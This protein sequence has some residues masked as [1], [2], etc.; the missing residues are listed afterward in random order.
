MN[1]DLLS[2]IEKESRLP[3]LNR[4]PAGN[5]HIGSTAGRSSQTELR[6]G[7]GKPN[8]HSYIY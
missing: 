1:K 4:G 7:Y 5:G 3:D 8:N 6:R 2:L